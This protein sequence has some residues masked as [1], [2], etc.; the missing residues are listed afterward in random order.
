MRFTAL[1]FQLFVPEPLFCQFPFNNF[2]PQFVVG[3][4]KFRGSLSNPSIEFMGDPFLLQ[5]AALLLVAQLMPD[6]PLHSK[7]GCQ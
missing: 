1:Q 2:F 7:E 6:S 5:L 4:S 3:C